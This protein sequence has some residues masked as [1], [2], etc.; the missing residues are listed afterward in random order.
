LRL[1]VAAVSTGIV[2]GEPRL[3]LAYTEDSA[4]D[5]D[6]NFVLTDTGKFVEIQ[7]T[8]ESE[9]FSSEEYA[10]MVALAELGAKQLFE[11]QKDALARAKTP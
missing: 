4:A 8:A 9:P 11:L 6:F 2:A 3:D 5:V 7:G 10:K 1:S